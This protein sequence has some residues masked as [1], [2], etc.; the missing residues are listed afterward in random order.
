MTYCA[1]TK[2]TTSPWMM[3]ARL[4]AEVRREDLGIEVPRRRARLERGE[5]QR[6]EADADRRVPSEQRDG[7]AREP[8]RR[9]LDLR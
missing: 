1:P 4:E 3:I 9:A 8:D 6:G 5:Q 7:D 2:S